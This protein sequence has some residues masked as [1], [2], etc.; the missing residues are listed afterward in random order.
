M[1]QGLG[2]QSDRRMRRVR[3]MR[4]HCG[5]IVIVDIGIVIV[6]IVV[7]DM[8]LAYEAWGGGT[9]QDRYCYLL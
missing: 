8:F 3:R 1:Q 4:G 2:L 7:L 5:R 6:M 9:D